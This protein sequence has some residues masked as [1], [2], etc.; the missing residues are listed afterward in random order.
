MCDDNIDTFM[1]ALH[2]VIFAT[3]LCRR[4]FSIITLMNFG[5]NC[6]FQKRFCTVYFG[7]KEKNTVNLPHS[8][9]TKHAYLEEI[10]VISETK[11]L[12]S[13]KKNALELLHQRLGKR[14]T[15]SL[16][17][18]DTDNVWEDIKLRID[19]ENFGTSCHIS[20]AQ[21]KSRSKSTKAKSTLQVGFYGHNTINSTIKFEK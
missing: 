9:Q 14:S 5:H 21:K 19:P 18:G 17:T 10:K 6:L 3:D 1:A 2:N 8:A 12:P 16:L 13:R 20:S 11:K 4:I 7:N 15:R